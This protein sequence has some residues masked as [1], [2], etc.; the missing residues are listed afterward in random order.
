LFSGRNENE[1]ERFDRV[2]ESDNSKHLVHPSHGRSQRVVLDL[3][4]GVSGI[5]NPFGSTRQIGNSYAFIDF[6]AHLP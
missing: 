5:R 4:R 1:D 2:L 6:L 3:Q